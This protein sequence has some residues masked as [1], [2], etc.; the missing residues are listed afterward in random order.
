MTAPATAPAQPPVNPADAD[1]GA[2]MHHEYDGIQEYDNPLP[3]WWS[4]L[5]VIT[6]VYS[7]WYLYWY[8][9]GGSGTSVHE[10]YAAELRAWEAKRAAAPVEEL[11]LDEEQLAQLAGES[12]TLQQGRGVYVKNCVSCHL[13]DGRGQIGPNLTDLYQIHGSGRV[14]IFR[15]IYDGVPDKG[16]LTWSSVLPP[17]EIAAVSA[18]VVTLRGRQVAGKP[19]EGRAVERFR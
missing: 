16:M 9:L 1:H 6:I 15:T 3:F 17:D 18:Y 13:D 14:D 19:P 7:A 12:S 2:L 4:G 8:H 10:D 5:F 11:Q